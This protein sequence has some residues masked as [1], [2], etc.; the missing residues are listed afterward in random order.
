MYIIGGQSSSMVNV[1]LCVFASVAAAGCSVDDI[2][3]C[4]SASP[5]KFSGMWWLFRFAQELHRL[6]IMRISM[7]TDTFE[8]CMT[9]VSQ[10]SPL[11]F[12][13]GCVYACII[14]HRQ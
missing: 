4:L 9:E 12:V 2:L 3:R 5:P 8:Y 13:E 7:E 1:A 14:L 6:Y 10:Y 11:R